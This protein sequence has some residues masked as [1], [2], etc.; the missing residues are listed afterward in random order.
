MSDSW[1]EDD[2]L[3]PE[4]TAVENAGSNGGDRQALTVRV[5]PVYHGSE[6]RA[7]PGIWIE[8]IPDYLHSRPQGP[9]LIDV[10]TWI[11]LDRAV[12]TRLRRW[13]RTRRMTWRGRRG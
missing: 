10:Q 1:L 8:Y 4:V 13:P 3:S 6:R 7:E 12:R 9:V 11:A 5:G 2:G